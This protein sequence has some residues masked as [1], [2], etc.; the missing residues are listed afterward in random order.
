MQIVNEVKIGGTIY[1]AAP[2]RASQRDH[3]GG[4]ND[5]AYAYWPDEVVPRAPIEKTSDNKRAKKRQ[6]AK[7][8]KQPG[9]TGNAVGLS[10]PDDG[11]SNKPTGKKL[12]ETALE[13]N[14][15]LAPVHLQCFVRLSG[16]QPGG[17]QVQRR[18]IDKDGLYAV[19]H[20]VTQYPPEP[21]P[22]SLLFQYAIKDIP[23]DDISDQYMDKNLTLYMIPVGHIKKPCICV[24]DM[25][26]PAKGNDRTVRDCTPRRGTYFMVAP[27]NSWAT[28]F[29]NHMREKMH[30]EDLAD[31]DLLLGDPDM[32]Y[33]SDD[34]SGSDYEI[35]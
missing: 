17:L 9:E 12:G 20:A 26:G 10:F 6:P 19:C 28:I 31:E 15:R 25:A 2:G 35:D 32:N 3:K 21:V 7:K 29:L 1:R 27:S 13:K 11:S 16:V 4:W 24:P 23:K 5:W 8:R 14:G 22:D 18:A 30:R 34:E 33:N